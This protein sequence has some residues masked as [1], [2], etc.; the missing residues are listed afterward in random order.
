MSNLTWTDNRH[1]IPKGHAPKWE[2][3]NGATTDFDR[4][5]GGK[6]FWRITPIHTVMGRTNTTLGGTAERTMW[7]VEFSALEAPLNH[8]TPMT[9]HLRYEHEWSVSWRWATC[10]E[11]KR[12]LF[13]SLDEAKEWCE[14]TYGFSQVVNTKVWDGKWD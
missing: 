8:W 14:Q 4:Y 3:E 1:N 2:W 11:T 6:A 13:F 7:F 9:A 10:D 12:Y 5:G